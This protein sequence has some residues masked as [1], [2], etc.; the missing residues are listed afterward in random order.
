[1]A[2][3]EALSDAAQ[4]LHGVYQ[5]DENHLVPLSLAGVKTESGDPLV[6]AYTLRSRET[7]LPELRAAGAWDRTAT[8]LRSALQ[9]AADGLLAQGLI[10]TAAHEKYFMSL[11]QQE[12]IHGLP[13]YRRASPRAPKTI[14]LW[15]AKKGAEITRLEFDAGVC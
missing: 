5:H 11:T 2:W 9:K 12:I 3:H 13:G 10:G 15:N 6:S 7:E 1:L 14:R 8:L 4:T